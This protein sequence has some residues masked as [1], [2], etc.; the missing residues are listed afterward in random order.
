[1]VSLFVY[2]LERRPPTPPVPWR[3]LL[4]SKPQVCV[5]V[6][7][8]VGILVEVMFILHSCLTSQSSRDKVEFS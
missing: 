2:L 5:W 1:M 8:V 3:V 4:K 6:R 7:V